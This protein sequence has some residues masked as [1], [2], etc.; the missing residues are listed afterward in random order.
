MVYLRP[1]HWKNEKETNKVSLKG[2][3]IKCILKRANVSEA[4][5][6]HIEDTVVDSKRDLVELVVDFT[7]MIE[8]YH[9]VSEKTTKN[10]WN[11]SN[12]V[13]FQ[14][15]TAN[16]FDKVQEGKASSVIASWY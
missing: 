14:V 10:N 7:K 15:Q 4:E 2:T 13:K 9:R 5:W 1:G 8:G 6:E 16:K 3:K 11:R 12:H